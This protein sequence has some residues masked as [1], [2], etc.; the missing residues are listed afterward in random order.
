MSNRRRKPKN[1]PPCEVVYRPPAELAD[2]EDL[3]EL[4]TIFAD[5]E[6]PKQ[7]AFL[8]G[9]IR[10]RGL[11]QAARL[12]G[13]HRNSHYKWM[14]TDPDYRERFE[15]ARKVVADEAE[16]EVFRRVFHGFHTPI[17]YHGKITGWYKS[18]SD[19]LAMFVLRALKPR[20]YGRN[21]EP[22]YE[23]P[24]SMEITILKEGE[25][26]PEPPPHLPQISIPVNDPEE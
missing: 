6:N 26:R 21:A 24:T 16:E 4:R 13:V 2:D 20:V 8:A 14:D 11:R 9:F 7:R 22:E 12:S 3:A 10:A 17:I 1:P 23:G 18:H 15:R 19:A 5:I 25:P